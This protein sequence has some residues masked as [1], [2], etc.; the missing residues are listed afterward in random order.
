MKKCQL[1]FFNIHYWISIL[2]LLLL[3]WLFLLVFKN[4]NYKFVKKY[5]K[6][7]Q[8][9]KKEPEKRQIKKFANY[10]LR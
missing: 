2:L 9:M 6:I 4:N 1:I 5:L 8:E 7:S 10:Y 3:Q